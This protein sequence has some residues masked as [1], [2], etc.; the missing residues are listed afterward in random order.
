MPK[1]GLQVLRQA[2]GL[3]PNSTSAVADGN[4]L[5]N[6]L[7]IAIDFENVDNIVEG[8]L[9]RVKKCQAGIAT[10]DPKHIQLANH[11]YD[12]LISTHNIISGSPD[13]IAKA[14]EQF[15]FGESTVAD[16]AEVIKSMEDI[17]PNDVP[18]VLIG[19]GLEVDMRILKQEGFGF[20]SR[21]ITIVDTHQVAKEMF[22]GCSYTLSHLLTRLGRPHHGLHSAGNDANF[23]LRA[24]LL[25]ATH[26]GRKQAQGSL[27]DK[28]ISTALAGI[29]LNPDLEHGAPLEWDN[30]YRSRSSIRKHGP[31]MWTLEEQRQRYAERRERHAQSL[32]QLYCRGHG[33]LWVHLDH[34]SD[35]SGNEE[36]EIGEEKQ[37]DASVSFSIE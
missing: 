19:H 13:Y 27:A 28:I 6:A 36:G 25:L 4:D 29:P 20:S 5:V 18:V 1:P 11:D 12:Q 15:I 22:K 33:A 10:L 30:C 37:L 14:S 17:I 9:V 23:A 8:G 32:L 34:G 7:L 3:G 26:K 16:P 31:N 24:A 21:Q 35:G 2:L